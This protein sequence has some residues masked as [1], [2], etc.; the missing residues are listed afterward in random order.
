MNIPP[1]DL[2]RHY[3]PLRKEIRKRIDAVC[4]AQAF[5]LGKTVSDFEDAF[6]QYCGSTYAIGCANGTDAILLSLKVAGITCGDEVLV[7][8]F[9]F[10]ASAEPIARLGAT[11]VFCDIDKT[12]YNIDPALLESKITKK[13]K[14]IVVVHL[15][16]Q[17]ADMKPIMALARKYKL[18]VIED[19]CQAIGA[20]YGALNKKAGTFGDCACFSFF[21][22][23]NL[24]GFGDGGMIITNNKKYADELRMLRQHGSDKRYYHDM[25][26]MNSR[27]DALQATV[28][29]VKLPHL[30]SWLSQR[31]AKAQVYTNLLRSAFRDNVQTPI[32][33]KGNTHTFHQYTLQIEGIEKKKRDDLVA[34]LQSQ[35]IGS[36]V[37]YPVPCHKQKCFQY[38]KKKALLPVTERVSERAFSLPIFPE[39]KKEEQKYI[40]DAIEQYVKKSA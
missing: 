12:T 9:T 26:G 35:G 6:A 40:V 39:L 33:E 15:Y 1:L 32:V 18:K 30:E 37:Y 19:A 24:G 21:P 27:L 11:P 20:I 2:K 28:L 4:D 36:M 29:H 10:I 25:L 5:I 23:K 31:R 14:A 34:Y 16:G 17:T 7:P 38:L 13:T 3:K 8:S 22:T